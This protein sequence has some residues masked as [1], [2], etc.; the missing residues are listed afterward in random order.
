[1]INAGPPLEPPNWKDYSRASYSLATKKTRR[2][3]IKQCLIYIAVG[4]VILSILGAIGGAS[5][6]IYCKL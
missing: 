3:K 2:E 5:Y 4:I 6:A 1:M